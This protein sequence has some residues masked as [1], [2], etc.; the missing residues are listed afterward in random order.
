LNVHAGVENALNRQNFMG[1]AWMDNCSIKNSSQT[2]CGDNI[3][4]IPGVPETEITQMPVFP[5][6]GIHYDF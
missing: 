6:A 1:Y 3:N 4:A 5:S 2:M